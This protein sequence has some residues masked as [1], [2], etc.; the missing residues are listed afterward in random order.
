MSPLQDAVTSDPRMGGAEALARLF[1]ACG[2]DG[3]WREQGRRGAMCPPR[4]AEIGFDTEA[5]SPL[6]T[7]IPDPCAA[8]LCLAP[9]ATFF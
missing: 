5:A 6:N 8:P 4:G 7:T 1:H 9:I 2:E 3:F